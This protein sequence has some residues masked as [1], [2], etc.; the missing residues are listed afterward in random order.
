MY[1]HTYMYA[2]DVQQTKEEEEEALRVE[3][4]KQQQR[5]V[6]VEILKNRLYSNFFNS[7]LSSKLILRISA[8]QKTKQQQ[9]QVLREILKSR[10]YGDCI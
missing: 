7:K 6:L 3:R 2:A 4:A 10:L 8:V 9:R 5:R 1:M